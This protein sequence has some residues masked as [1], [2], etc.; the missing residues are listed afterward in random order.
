MFTAICSDIILGMYR[1]LFLTFAYI[2]AFTF[3][4]GYSM[5]PMLQRECVEK[6]KWLGEDKML[7]FYTIA[8]CLPGIIAC[9]TAA[10]TGHF[11]RG[12]AGAAAA[13]AGVITP[14]II[15]IMIIAGALHQFADYA[16]VNHA[17]AGIQIG[18]A[19]LIAHTVIKLWRTG[20]KSILAVIICLIAFGLSV[21]PAKWLPFPISPIMIILCAAVTGIVV[22]IIRLRRRA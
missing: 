20:V 11:C 15:I 13:A 7:D 6:N 17:F 5:L 16:V 14:S 22:G 10:L 4:G 1:K 18:V 3:G 21:V 19:A 9:N 12:I 8:Q 2:G